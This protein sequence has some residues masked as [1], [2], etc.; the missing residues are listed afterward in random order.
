MDM[1]QILITAPIINAIKILNP[2]IDVSMYRLVH[3]L[4]TPK[5]YLTLYRRS[6]ESTVNLRTPFKGEFLNSVLDVISYRRVNK[7]LFFHV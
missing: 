3:K 1:L 2:N 7:V 6:Y 5:G 4:S